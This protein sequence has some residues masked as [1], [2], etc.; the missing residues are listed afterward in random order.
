MKRSDSISILVVEDNAGD[1]MLFKKTL[2]RTPIAV[3]QLHWAKSL[4]EAAVCLLEHSIDLAFLDLSLPDSQGVSTFH[5]LNA[6]LPDTPIIVLSGLADMEVAVETIEFGAQDYLVKGE[7]DE[8]LLA[9]SVQYSIGRKRI[10]EKLRQSNERFEIVNKATMDVIWDLDFKAHEMYMSSSLSEVLGYNEEVVPMEW[11]FERIH[12]DDFERTKASLAEVLKNTVKNWSGEYRML[13]SDGTY[14]NIYAKG[15]VLFDN[16]GIAYRM[17]GAASDIT[18][19]RMLEEML[20]TQEINQQKLITETTIRAQEKERNELAKELHDNINQVL[21]TVKL[22][23]NVA[24]DDAAAREE[25]VGRSYENVTY[26]IEEIRKL[27]RS[28]VAPSLGDIGLK[29][30]LEDLAAEINLGKKVEVDLQLDMAAAK[31]VD[32]DIELML[33]RIAQE[34]LNNVLKYAKASRATVQVMTSAKAVRMSVSDNGVGFVLSEKVK[35]IGLKNIKSRVEFHEGKL[36]ITTAPG[37]GCTLEVEVPV[38]T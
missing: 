37:A 30:A 9:K 5:S 12:P 28:L 36:K 18:E 8:K 32:S 38:V 17:I 7:F 13:G 25:L 33:Y 15:Y 19:K 2:L 1:Y 21:A 23:L 4:S 3:G 11:F 24:R 20:H 10:I 22:F 26:A 34:Q 16:E 35:G 6:Q 29:E 27:S 14:K 31:R